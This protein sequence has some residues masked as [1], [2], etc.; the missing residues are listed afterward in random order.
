VTPAIAGTETAPAGTDGAFSFTVSLAKGAGS[1]MTTVPTG[2]IVATPHASTPV[3]RIELLPPGTLTVRILNT[4]NVATGEL[5]L[6][7]S[8][9]NADV[10]TFPSA[11]QGSLPVGGDG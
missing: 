11:T 4:G 3:K 9:A 6:A 7:L 5:T 1:A 10:F 8:G 2:V